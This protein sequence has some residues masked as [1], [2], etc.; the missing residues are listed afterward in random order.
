MEDQSQTNGTACTPKY[1][2][3][4]VY[5]GERHG[6]AADIFS[7]GC[8]FSEMITVLCRRSLDDFTVH[9]RDQYGKE[10]FHCNLP[11]VYDWLQL[12]ENCRPAWNFNSTIRWSWYNAIHE[13][14]KTAKGM[15]SCIIAML[16]PLST[17]RP[18]IK[19]I[20]PGEIWINCCPVSSNAKKFKEEVAHPSKIW[21]DI[22]FLTNERL[23][24][25]IIRFGRK[26]LFQELKLRG[27]IGSLPSQLRLKCLF[28]AKLRGAKEI[29]QSII[30][31]DPQMLHCGMVDIIQ[32]DLSREATPLSWAAE[33]GHEAVI[34]LLLESGKVDVNMKDD[35]SR[36]PLWWAAKNGHEAIVG[37]LLRSENV[38]VDIKDSD[39]RTP[40]SWAANNG[41]VA[42]VK[43]LLES[44]KV[45]VNT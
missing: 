7:L 14:T 38:D 36:T 43:L 10:A 1:C 9:R 22:D 25:E 23:L 3:P 21:E 44:K 45:N 27:I 2:A 40:L 37:L 35:Y 12:L 39:S 41:H 26:D 28:T 42:V 24:E 8:V 5:N 19:N 17:G 15:V 34:R 4:E 31:V 32:R 13:E 33:N 30:E 29:M 20:L 11:R 18:Y 16:S 6:R